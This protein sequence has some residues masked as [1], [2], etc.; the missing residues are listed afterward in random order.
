MPG[1]RPGA[2]RRLLPAVWQRRYDVGHYLLKIAYD[3]AT[4]RLAG[5]ATITARATER[6]CRFNLDFQGVTVRSVTV[7]GRRA[8][9]SRR[10][11]HELMV[12]PRHQLRK[13]RKFTVVVR[14]DGVPRTQI[15]LSVPE[16]PL[17]Y[18]W[19]HTDDGSVV[20]S[21]PEGSANWF[22]LNDHPTDKAT[23]TFVVTVPK[24]HEAISN[25]RMVGRR[26]HGRRTTW[27]WD[28]PDPMAPTWPRPP[29]A[30]SICAPTGRPRGCCCTTRSTPTCTTSRPTPRTRRRR[31]WARSRTARWPVGPAQGRRQRHHRP[32]HRPGRAP[33]GR[34]VGRAVRRLAVHPGKPALATPTA[35]GALAGAPATAASAPR[36][37][38]AA[39]SLLERS[40]TRASR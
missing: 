7:D 2:R 9:R 3:P 1:G 40:S 5:T 20:V 22:P 28:A 23:F 19:I 39:A 4:D 38:P 21:E 32:V 34:A 14:Y 15:D 33:L 13:G 29:S 36:T 30:S 18:G 27:V 16:E 35:A 8:R 17:P 37:P 11:D 26:T 24:G 31:P 25:G 12:T 10:Q 6:L